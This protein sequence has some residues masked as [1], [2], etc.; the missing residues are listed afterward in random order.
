MMTNKIPFENQIYVS[1][2][3]N[4]NES[5][6]LLNIKLSLPHNFHVV[7]TPG[8]PLPPSLIRLDIL[9]PCHPKHYSVQGNLLNFCSISHGSFFGTYKQN[10]T[11]VMLK[12]ADMK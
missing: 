10:N 9:A 7:P 8:F 5:N 12:P 3:I 2:K 11:A 6:M 1:V 4:D